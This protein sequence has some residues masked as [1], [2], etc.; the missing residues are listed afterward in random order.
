[1]TPPLRTMAAAFAA[2][3]MSPAVLAG[4]S[5]LDRPPNVSGDWVV[6]LGVIQFNFQHRFDASPAPA[7]KVTNYPTFVMAAGLPASTMIGFNYSTNSLLAPGYPNEWEFFGRWHPVSQDM[8]APIDFGVEIAYNNAAKGVDGE[9]SIAR[10]L[11]RLRVIGV[12]RGLS[13]P[14][15]TSGDAQV[16]LGGGATLRL[17]NWLAVQGDYASLTNLQPGEKAAWS[18]G[19][20]IGIPTTPHSLALFASN[21]VTSTL[22]GA[23]RGGDQVL[24][25]FEFTVPLTLSRWFGHK[26]RPPAPAAA[27]AAPVSGKAVTTLIKGMAFPQAHIEIAVG[28]TITWK[29]EDQVSHTVSATDTSFDSGMI[30]AGRSWSH[31]FDQPGTYTYYCTPH[32]FMKGTVVV[33]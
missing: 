22:Q 1:V 9:V 14:Y 30:D 17:L 8:G 32:P 19:L 5:V 23:S 20:A 28:T 4:Q 18:A 21:A 31:T 29:N 12:A 10:R 16:A 11:G 15:S 33:K 25:G 24:Y 6:R 27:A 2:A 3:C 13:D 7:R 26:A